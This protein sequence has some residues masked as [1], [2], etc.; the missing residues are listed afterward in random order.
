MISNPITE[1]IRET[2]HQLA[3]EQGNDVHRIGAEL[4]RRQAASGRQIVRLPKRNPDPSTTNQAMHPR[5]GGSP[6]GN[7]ESTP[8]AG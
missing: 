6:I 7:V 2:R 1:E 5:G 8:A 4:R 3:A